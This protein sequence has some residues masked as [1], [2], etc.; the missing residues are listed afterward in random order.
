MIF[1]HSK[2]R[3]VTGSDCEASHGCGA[4]ARLVLA[5]VITALI[6]R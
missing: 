2:Q 3:T 6:G 5:G 4:E 1:L